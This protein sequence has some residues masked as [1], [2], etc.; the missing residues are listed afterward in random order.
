MTFRAGEPR[1][2]THRLLCIYLSDHLAGATAGTRRVRRLAKAVSHTPL[3]ADVHA[4]AE[5]IAKDRQELQRL[6]DQTGTR[7]QRYKLYLA[8]GLEL[9]GR[10]KLN[11]RLTRRSPLSTLVELEAIS[12]GI[13]G[14]AA[15][16]RTLHEIAETDKRVSPQHLTELDIRA[17]D[18]AQRAEELRTK[19]ARAIF[20]RGQ[21]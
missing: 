8:A 15:G 14:K 12:L 1:D 19:A 20:A 5:E 6:I 11:G 17:R 18:Q 21:R 4:L 13:Q 3:G 7:V 16:W 10:L 2:D 9:V